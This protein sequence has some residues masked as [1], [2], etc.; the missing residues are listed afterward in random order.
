M[1][2]LHFVKKKSKIN[3]FRAQ[4]ATI[5]CLIQNIMSSLEMKYDWISL[6]CGKYLALFKNF[7]QLLL[8]LTALS[9]SLMASHPLS[10]GGILTVLA[11]DTACE[12]SILWIPVPQGTEVLSCHFQTCSAF[13]VICFSHGHILQTCCCKQ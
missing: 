5:Y 6:V 9:D 8:L 13:L 11:P 7:S 3:T 1:K 4:W 12:Y 10:A 2:N